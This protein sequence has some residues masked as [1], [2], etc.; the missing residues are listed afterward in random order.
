GR[1]RVLAKSQQLIAISYY[2]NSDARRGSQASEEGIGLCMPR[3]GGV[4]RPGKGACL[5][6]RGRRG[7]L[8]GLRLLLVGLLGREALLLVE[9][10]LVLLFKVRLGLRVAG[11]LGELRL[12][13]QQVGLVRP[14][15]RAVRVEADGLLGE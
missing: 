8:R 5:L 6:A 2:K 3:V 12:L 10:R 9:R 4:G 15:A 7:R 14:C 1:R 11:H 13:A